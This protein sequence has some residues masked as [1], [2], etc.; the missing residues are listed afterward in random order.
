MGSGN[1]VERWWILLLLAVAAAGRGGSVGRWYQLFYSTRCKEMAA[2]VATA[3]A[4]GSGEEGE[5]AAGLVAGTT[6][7]TL[8]AIQI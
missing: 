6:C 8:P 7:L 1:E 3:A 5:R 2:A 4:T